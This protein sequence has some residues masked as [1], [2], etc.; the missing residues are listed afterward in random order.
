MQSARKAEAKKKKKSQSHTLLSPMPS[1]ACLLPRPP[2]PCLPV[3]LPCSPL[4]ISFPCLFPLLFRLR[5]LLLLLLLL[6]V[7]SPRCLRQ[8]SFRP[9]AMPSV[10]LNSHQVSYTKSIFTD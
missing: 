10:L 3:D 6:L 7:L 2:S 8:F 5:L 4:W 1:G 9:E